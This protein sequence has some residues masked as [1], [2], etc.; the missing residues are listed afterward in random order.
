MNAVLIEPI[1]ESFKAFKASSGIGHITNESEYDHAIALVEKLVEAGALEDDSPLIDLYMLVADVVQ[2]YEQ[3][4]YPLPE[5]S[6]GDMLRFL[7][8]QHGLRQADLVSE[9]GSQSVVSEILAGRR[10]LNRKHITSL[11]RRFNVSPAVF[12]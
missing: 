6:G 2:Q 10:E 11:A 5:L 1:A 7:M 3:K 4:F 8:D 12:F 9:L